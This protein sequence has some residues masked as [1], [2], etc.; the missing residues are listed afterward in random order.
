[1]QS[2]NEKMKERTSLRRKYHC[3]LGDW[4][5]TVEG[6]NTRFKVLNH[7]KTLPTQ[8][9]FTLFKKKKRDNG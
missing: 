8:N 2:Q 3:A 4:E 7:F 1:M 5:T 6:K 9:T